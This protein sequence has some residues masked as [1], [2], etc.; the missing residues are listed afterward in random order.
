LIKW[1]HKH[2]DNKWRIF[3]KWTKYI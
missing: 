1:F 3:K 2:R